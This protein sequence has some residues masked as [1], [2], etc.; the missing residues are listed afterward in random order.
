MH[1]CSAH[2]RFASVAHPEPGD[3]D[4]QEMLAE[5]HTGELILVLSRASALAGF[6]VT[7]VGRISGDR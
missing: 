3:H 7:A 4:C 2:L 1:S 6:E 5:N